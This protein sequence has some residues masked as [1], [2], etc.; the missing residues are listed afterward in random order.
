M[1]SSKLYKRL[2]AATGGPWKGRIAKPKISLIDATAD[3]IS[4]N[5][6]GYRRENRARNPYLAPLF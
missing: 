1:G 4:D 2:S 5:M 6:S 3:N